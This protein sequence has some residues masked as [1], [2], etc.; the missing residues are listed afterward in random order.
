MRKK[1]LCWD[2][3]PTFTKPQTNLKNTHF[4]F[5][6]DRSQNKKRLNDTFVLY[7]T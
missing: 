6:I 3:F 4:Y 1:C 5:D 2:L 7:T